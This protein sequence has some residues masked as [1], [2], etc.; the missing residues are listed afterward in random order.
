MPTLMWILI[1]WGYLGMRIIIGW[2]NPSSTQTIHPSWVTISRH[3]TRVSS[4]RHKY[5]RKL[6]GLHLNSKRSLTSWRQLKRSIQHQMC[7]VTL[8]QIWRKHCSILT[9]TRITT[10]R[11]RP[12][13]ISKLKWQVRQQMLGN[14]CMAILESTQL[15]CRWMEKDLWAL[16]LRSG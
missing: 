11:R 6:T 7:W 16:L 14:L 4:Y 15:W 1:W 8:R 5:Q 3:K 10:I 2:S 13:L 9:H 12:N